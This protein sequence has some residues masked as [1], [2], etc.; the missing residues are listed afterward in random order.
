[1][2]RRRFT[3]LAALAL[4]LCLLVLLVTVDVAWREGTIVVHIK[5]YQVPLLAPLVL[6]VALKNKRRMEAQLRDDR[7]RAGLCAACG[8]DLRA[9]PERCPECGTTS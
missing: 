5:W 3:T 2:K 4:L 1:V 8:Y 6:W 7:R 9:T